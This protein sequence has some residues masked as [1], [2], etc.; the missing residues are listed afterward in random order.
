MRNLNFLNITDEKELS[1]K[2]IVPLLRKMGY[3]SVQYRCGFD[4]FGR[5]IIFCELDKFR[6]PRWMGAQVKAVKIHGTSSRSKGNVQEII[7]KIQE[8]FD[9]PFFETASNKEEY[10]KDMYII[11]SREITPKA[12]VSIKNRFRNQNVHFI[13]GQKLIEL[14][15]MHSP[16]LLYTDQNTDLIKSK[17]LDYAKKYKG[18]IGSSFMV[19]RELEE[20]YKSKVKLNEEEQE[21]LC[22]IFANALFNFHTRYF[23]TPE[24]ISWLDC[25]EPAVRIITEHINSLI[26]RFPFYDQHG[27]PAGTRSILDSLRLIKQNAKKTYETLIE[28]KKIDVNELVTRLTKALNHLE[29]PYRNGIFL[30]VLESSDI[31]KDLSES[32]KIFFNLDDRSRLLLLISFEYFDEALKLLNEKDELLRRFPE[33][34]SYYVKEATNAIG[35]D[36]FKFE[37]LKIFEK[38]I[39]LSETSKIV[40]EEGFLSALKT[41]YRIVLLVSLNRLQ[42]AKKLLAYEEAYGNIGGEHLPVAIERLFGNLDILLRLLQGVEYSTKNP[43]FL[44]ELAEECYKNTKYKLALTYADEAWE[45]RESFYRKGN[46]WRINWVKRCQARSHFKLKNYEKCY[47][48]YQS[49][50]DEKQ[51]FIDWKEYEFCKTKSIKNH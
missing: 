38:F 12:S 30:E 45:K 28:E 3:S 13:D 47:M 34:I 8:A 26:A 40:K 23:G 48:I 9:N 7:N 27:A 21:S 41:N 36:G 49:L 2:V 14:I 29:Y 50:I 16:S 39:K 32:E 15:Q 10:I 51:Y 46:E 31:I 44:L 19:V 5:D 22:L 18:E 6:N 25:L 1:K 17:I 11:T 20:W 33:I 24:V 4:E 35:F 37:F 43:S 42:E